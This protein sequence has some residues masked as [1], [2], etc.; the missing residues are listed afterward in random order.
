MEW[1]GLFTYAEQDAEQLKQVFRRTLGDLRRD[2]STR[3]FGD[4][5]AVSV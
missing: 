2:I 5:T 3:L 1:R 4:S